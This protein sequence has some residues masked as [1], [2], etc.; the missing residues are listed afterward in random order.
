VYASFQTRHCSTAGS[1]TVGANGPWPGRY[2]AV[3]AVVGK[4]T[5]RHND[6]TNS[7]V[8]VLFKTITRYKSSGFT[9]G[10]PISVVKKA[11]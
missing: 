3:Y 10:K 2:V 4:V 5:R 7:P 11:N 8:L 9:H 6:V 1:S